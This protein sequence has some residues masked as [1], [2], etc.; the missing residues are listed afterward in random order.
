[1]K[2][3]KHGKLIFV[4]VLVIIL[5]LQPPVRMGV[6]HLFTR[7]DLFNQMGVKKK[8]E[9]KINHDSNN[10]LKKLANGVKGELDKAKQAIK[11]K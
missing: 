2:E 9:Q 4:I 6:Y 1:M 5:A 10:A 8:T 3:K 11:N 7:N